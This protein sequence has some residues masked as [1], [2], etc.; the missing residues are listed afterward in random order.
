MEIASLGTSTV[1]IVSTHFHSAYGLSNCAALGLLGDIVPCKSTQSLPVWALVTVTCISR[2][3]YTKPHYDC[4]RCRL[5]LCLCEIHVGIFGRRQS[6]ALNASAMTGRR[7]QAFA[8]LSIVLSLIDVAGTPTLTEINRR[9]GKR[10]NM[11]YCRSVVKSEL[12]FTVFLHKAG[13]SRTEMYVGLKTVDYY[14]Y[15]YYLLRD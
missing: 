9:S 2:L 3:N 6:T 1:P 7:R 4:K 8:R 13:S 12:C 5:Q 14:Y 15:Y 10:R 11:K